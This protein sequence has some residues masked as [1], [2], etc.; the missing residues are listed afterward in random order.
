MGK[1]Q[2]APPESSRVVVPL[3]PERM[4]I[5]EQH[6]ITRR[7]ARV[8]LPTVQRDFSELWSERQSREPTSWKKQGS[9]GN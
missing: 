5:A 2:K 3:H 4:S 9:T 6:M 8:D 7:R 1:D